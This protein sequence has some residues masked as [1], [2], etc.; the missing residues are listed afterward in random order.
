MKTSYAKVF[1]IGLLLM[2]AIAGSLASYER[3]FDVGPD[4]ETYLLIFVDQEF[5]VEL[6]WDFIRSNF[7][8]SDQ[9]VLTLYSLVAFIA[10]TIKLSVLNRAGMAAV[11][12][13]LYLST[14]Y[15]L[16]EYIQIRVAMGLAIVYLVLLRRQT[17]PLSSVLLY[18][19]PALFH[20]SLA[21]LAV[22]PLLD[23]RTLLAFSAVPIGF[24]LYK[25]IQNEFLSEFATRKIGDNS[26]FYIF[27]ILSAYFFAVQ[28]HFFVV[29]RRFQVD[30]WKRFHSASMTFA[31]LA[32]PF[33]F[34]QFGTAFFRFQEISASLLLPA[35]FGVLSRN[36]RKRW[37]YAVFFSGYYIL[38]AIK[39]YRDIL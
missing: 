16:H 36:N 1:T 7:S 13:P 31:L 4:H 20:Y 32:I 37:I 8:L 39:I 11:S 15:F 21:P 22:I 30:P 14:F 25:G 27:N 35:V 33:G 28:I 23:R 18:A 24:L 5:D 10:L 9:S 12:I 34:L 6:F 17:W 29:L 26:A 38:L 19:T 2:L 3:I